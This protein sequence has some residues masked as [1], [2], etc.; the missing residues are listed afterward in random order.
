MLLYAQPLSRI[1]RLTISD[2]ITGDNQQI[3]LRIGDPPSPVPE[4]FAALPREH[5]ATRGNMHTAANPNRGWLFPG[6]CAGQ[7][8]RPEVLGRAIR[9]MGMPTV[10]GRTAALRQL[11]LQ[12]PAPVVAGMLGFHIKHTARVHTQAGGTWNRYAL[13]EHQ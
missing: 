12:A 8:P 5:I 11:V 3:Q 13:G 4:P 1:V 7:P 6:R 9:A 10:L 2:I